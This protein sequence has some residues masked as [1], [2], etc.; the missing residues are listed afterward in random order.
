MRA[1]EVVGVVVLERGARRSE[2]ARVVS[3]WR[4]TMN[5]ATEYSENVCSEYGKL[6]ENDGSTDLRAIKLSRFIS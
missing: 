1:I 5:L 2:H 6:R 3:K 4:P